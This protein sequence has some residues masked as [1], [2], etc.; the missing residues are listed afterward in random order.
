MRHSA[1]ARSSSRGYC[2]ADVNGGGCHG[3]VHA[4][5]VRASCTAQRPVPD[6]LQG[7][8]AAAL[9]LPGCPLHRGIPPSSTRHARAPGR[10]V[11]AGHPGDC[12]RNRHPVHRHHTG[13]AVAGTHAPGPP[14]TSCREPTLG[15]HTNPLYRTSTETGQAR[16][17]T[18]DHPRGRAR[19]APARQPLKD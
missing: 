17:L 18:S 6:H 4:G 9:C 12:R 15:R 13:H 14:H 3:G 8:S 16:I 5:S 11:S 1:P 2:A 7:R 19:H 10:G